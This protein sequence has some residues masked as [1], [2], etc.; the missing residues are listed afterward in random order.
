MLQIDLY[1][2]VQTLLRDQIIWFLRNVPGNVGI[3]ETVKQYRS[4]IE[5]LQKA[6]DK[7]NEHLSAQD[8]A[9][10]KKLKETRQDFQKEIDELRAEMRSAVD[11]LGEEKVD[12]EQLGDLLIEMGNQ[13]K[14]NSMLSSVLDGLL[15]TDE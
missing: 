7:T 1:L 14:G 13:I 5:A 15:Q 12:R 2:A 6:L 4:G 11:R 10:S 8:N 3:G 9:Q